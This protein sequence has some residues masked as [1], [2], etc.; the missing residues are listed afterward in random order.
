MADWLLSTNFSKVWIR[1]E[2]KILSLCMEGN[3]PSAAALRQDP[4]K[5]QVKGFVVAAMCYSG[6][7]F[8]A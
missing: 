7:V 3:T 1:S 4:A 2:L 5:L 6:H 8:P